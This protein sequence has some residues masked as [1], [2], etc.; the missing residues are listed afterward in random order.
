[1]HTYDKQ[2]LQITLFPDDD[3]NDDDDDDDDDD[4]QHDSGLSLKTILFEIYLQWHCETSEMEKQEFLTKIF[5]S[6]HEKC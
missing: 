3:D 2:S 6:Y 5:Q 4:G 1:L